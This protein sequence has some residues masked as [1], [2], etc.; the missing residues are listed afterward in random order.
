M[1]GK[2]S[3]HKIRREKQAEIQSAASKQQTNSTLTGDGA[4]AR[5]YMQGLRAGTERIG[6]FLLCGQCPFAASRSSPSMPIEFFSHFVPKLDF[7]SYRSPTQSLHEHFPPH[8]Y[9]ES[10]RAK[11]PRKKRPLQEKFILL[12]FFGQDLVQFEYVAA[13]WQVEA[14]RREPATSSECCVS[15][16]KPYAKAVDSGGT[17]CAWEGPERCRDDMLTVPRTRGSGLKIEDCSNKNTRIS[18]AQGVSALAIDMMG[19]V[20]GQA[21]IDQIIVFALQRELF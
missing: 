17:R 13:K 5:S 1:C 3:Q 4:K 16:A 21:V 18:L 11:F 8:G 7:R 15:S 14:C 19:N 12:C 6:H 2:C 10:F 9:F 20:N